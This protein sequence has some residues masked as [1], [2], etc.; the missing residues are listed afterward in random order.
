VLVGL[1]LLLS[2][3]PLQRL[4]RLR[5]P[6]TWCAVLL[7]LLAIATVPFSLDIGRSFRFLKADYIKTV[8]IFL[9]VAAVPRSVTEVRRLALAYAAAAFVYSAVVLLRG[10]MA[11]GRLNDLYSYDSN[12]FAAL[13]A[14]SLPLAAMLL[15]RRRTGERM[16]G[17]AALP[18]L[19]LGIVASG[20]R[21]GL[22]AALFLLGLYVV[23][24]RHAT[25]WRR[26]VLL[27]F[28]LSVGVAA[29]A[30]FPWYSERIATIFDLKEDYNY[31]ADYG[32]VNIWKRGVGYMVT[33]PAT[34]VGIN[35]FGVAEG[36]ISKLAIERML[37]GKGTPFRAAHNSY[38][39]VGAELGLGGLLLF[40]GMLTAAIRSL[41]R[42]GAMKRPTA[43]DDPTRASL[44]SALAL[45][46]LT[47]A[48]A[49]IFLSQA[50]YSILYMLL[51]LV[52]ALAKFRPSEAS[53]RHRVIR[54]PSF[55]YGRRS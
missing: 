22:L 34:G 38:V 19:V 51:A 20:S 4:Q 3:H 47:W 28:V 10:N 15:E 46:L 45:S 5:H 48:V 7:L 1:L 26:T 29:M 44:A 2:T 9:L 43:T 36:T 21:G 31:D 39:Q 32:R 13:A 25:R 53:A 8:V 6:V 24:N 49:A 17:L 16:A 41:R 40:A 52:V 37:R 54:E 30:V 33:H 18:V 50:Y 14:A 42:D 55:G 27:G 12:D 11:E 23:L 35:A